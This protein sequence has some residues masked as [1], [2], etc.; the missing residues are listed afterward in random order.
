MRTALFRH[1]VA[2]G[3]HLQAFN[4]RNDA[5]EFFVLRDWFGTW[6]GRFPA[7]IDDRG[8]FLDHALRVVK[9]GIRFQKM[10]AV[11]E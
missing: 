2:N 11:I 7:N 5:P 1:G 8:A 10:P 6:A 9:G 4:N 3:Q